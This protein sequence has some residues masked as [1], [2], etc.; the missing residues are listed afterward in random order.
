MQVPRPS[1]PRG[2]ISP[3]LGRCAAAPSTERRAPRRR[4][5]SQRVRAI[6]LATPA[7]LGARVG[8]CRSSAPHRPRSARSRPKPRRRSER[9]RPGRG[10]R[11]LQ[12]VRQGAQINARPVREVRRRSEKPKRREPE[13]GDR[14]ELDDVARAFPLRKPRRQ[15]R[16]RRAVARS[17]PPTSSIATRRRFFAVAS[18]R[19]RR[20]KRG[21]V[22]ANVSSRV[23][24]SA[25]AAA[26][27]PR[28]GSDA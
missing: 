14:A 16:A 8:E 25:A 3:Q 2:A 1:R 26:R 22:S 15:A 9:R 6:P 4:E 20:T 19:E 12:L 18:K 21:S 17:T 11:R 28:S 10:A 23:P 5:A 13:G 27:T 24:P 7:A